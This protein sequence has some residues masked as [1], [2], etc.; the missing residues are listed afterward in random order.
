M[1]LTPK[2]FLR[3]IR[4]ALGASITLSLTDRSKAN[5]CYEAYVLGLIIT[6]AQNV[7]AHISYEDVYGRP[8]TQ[9]IF[10]T[11]PGHI[12]STRQNYTHAVIEFDNAPPLEA[13]MSIRY[14]GRSGVAHECDVSV[15]SR[16]EA[17]LC[18]RYKSIAQH[19]SIML[20]VECKYYESSRV[21]IGLT[22]EFLGLTSEIGKDNNYFVVNTLS[23]NAAIILENHDNHYEESVFPAQRQVEQ[24]VSHFQKRFDKYRVRARLVAQ[25]ED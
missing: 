17:Q 7:G 22:R 12:F 15:L 4:K 21:S 24:L 10:R 18:R 9:F 5:D 1:A 23:D 14:I 2:D 19:T 3:E 8:A 16:R 11:S 25:E 13:H 6:A 20:A